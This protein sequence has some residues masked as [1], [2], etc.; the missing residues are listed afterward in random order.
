MA[1][2]ALPAVALG[3]WA[4]LSLDGRLNPATFRKVLLWLLAA[5]GLKLVLSWVF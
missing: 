4:G 1:L 2:W 3:G 5:M